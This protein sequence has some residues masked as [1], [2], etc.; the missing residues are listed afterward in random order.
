MSEE[1]EI[2]LTNWKGEESLDAMPSSNKYQRDVVNDYI[3]NGNLSS[4]GFF[5]SILENN[6]LTAAMRADNSNV[7]QLKRWAT[8]LINHVPE[9]ARGSEFVVKHW[10]RMGGINGKSDR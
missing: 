9:A 7:L 2:N 5:R 3:M 8:W 10:I 1:K 4:T 6:F